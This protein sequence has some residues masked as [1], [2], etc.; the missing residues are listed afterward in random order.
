MSGLLHRL[1][2]VGDAGW[3]GDLCQEAA[4]ELARLREIVDKLPHKKVLKA[5]LL[6]NEADRQALFA[7][8]NVPPT[9]D[10]LNPKELQQ[11]LS[12]LWACRE[13]AKAAKE[14]NP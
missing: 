11:C 12:A 8:G 10:M 2:H 4:A 3:L 1:R 5:C 13:A 7:D 14:A 9:A 6:I